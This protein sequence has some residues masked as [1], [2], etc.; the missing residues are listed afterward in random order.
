MC[1]TGF[2]VVRA[3]T[4]SPSTVVSIEIHWRRLRKKCAN[5]LRVTIC[6]PEVKTF[7]FLRQY[8]WMHSSETRSVMWLLYVSRAAC[9]PR[10]ADTFVRLNRKTKVLCLKRTVGQYE[11]VSVSRRFLADHQ[12]HRT[13]VRCSE[14]FGGNPN[15]LIV[16]CCRQDS[17]FG[18]LAPWTCV[19]S[20][21]SRGRGHF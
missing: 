17:C 21:G 1:A 10:Q 13:S 11:I 18:H 19:R 12:H 9:K 15:P 7:S 14:T 4:G 5:H 3:E 16:R 2:N 6:P 8:S 20:S